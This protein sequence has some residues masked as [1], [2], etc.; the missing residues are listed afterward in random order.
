MIFVISAISLV[1]GTILSCAL[2]RFPVQ[3]LTIERCS[4]VMVLTGLALIGG[5]L[6][7]FR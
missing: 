5:G 4:G 2:D 6:P 7:L 3:K 1:V